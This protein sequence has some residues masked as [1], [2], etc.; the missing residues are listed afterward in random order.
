MAPTVHVSSS[1]IDLDF[2]LLGRPNFIPH[3]DHK[4]KRT[5]CHITSVSEISKYQTR[6]FGKDSA[7]HGRGPLE[8]RLI[9]LS[10]NTEWVQL[11]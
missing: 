11:S 10:I 2:F 1:E 6:K 8:K 5:F 7:A 3:N 9:F 4:S